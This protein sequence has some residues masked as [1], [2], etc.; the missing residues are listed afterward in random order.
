[1]ELETSWLLILGKYRKPQR[2]WQVKISDVEEVYH[3][4]QGWLPPIGTPLWHGKARKRRVEGV[5]SCIDSIR[6][7][8]LKTLEIKLLDVTMI[9]SSRS[10]SII[11]AFVGFM[12]KSL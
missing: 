2:G 5:E 7:H 4:S 11:V 1:M 9:F 12:P 6:I 10:T 3:N 8:H